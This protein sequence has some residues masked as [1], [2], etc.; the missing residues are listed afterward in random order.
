MTA[1]LKILVIDDN[2]GIPLWH[3]MDRE[4]AERIADEI[5][6]DYDRDVVV[7]EPRNEAE[8]EYAVATVGQC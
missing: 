2:G 4:E 5:E 3:G 8:W 6:R 7:R 1:T